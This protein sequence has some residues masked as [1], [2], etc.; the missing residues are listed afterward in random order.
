MKVSLT[1]G[2][3]E[4]A[5]GGEGAGSGQRRGTVAGVGV[6]NYSAT[7]TTATTAVSSEE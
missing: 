2:K 6:L 3:T 1:T 5:V 7:T 4:E